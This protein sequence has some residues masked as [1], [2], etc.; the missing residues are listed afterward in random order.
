M[1]LVSSH[2]VQHKYGI[3]TTELACWRRLGVGP[4]YY[5]FG[6]RTV[7]YDADDLDDWFH[8]PANAHL[9]HFPAKEIAELS[10]TWRR[11]A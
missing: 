10:I 11:D 1:I 7:R 3:T 9:H 2:D 4:E 6:P 8:D 5:V